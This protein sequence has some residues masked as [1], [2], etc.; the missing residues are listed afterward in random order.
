MAKVTAQQWLTNWSTGIS[1]KTQKIRDGISNTRVAP[2]AAAAA[3]KEKMRAGI[4]RA[5]DSGKWET[6]VAAVSLQDW[7]QS[8]LNKVGNIATGAA[9]AVKSAKV[10]NSVAQMLADNDA[11][12]AAIANM[13]SDTLDQRI[14]RSVA[15]QQ[16]RATIAAQRGK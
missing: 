14:Q 8:T 7:Q 9:N 10:A 1:N 6:N 5:I 15:Y 16:A 13:P 2:G 12:L 3:K 11:A 4:N